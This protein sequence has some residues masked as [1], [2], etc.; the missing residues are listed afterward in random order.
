MASNW[1]LSLQRA[2]SELRRVIIGPFI[3]RYQWMTRI[4]NTPRLNVSIYARVSTDKQDNANQLDLRATRRNS[5]EIRGSHSDRRVVCDP[6]GPRLDIRAPLPKPRACPDRRLG[7]AMGSFSFKASL[8]SSGH[9]RCTPYSV[10]ALR[11]T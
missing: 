8:W 1:S 7:G 5:R 11:F 6:C 10:P 2:V 4:S 9:L 3:A